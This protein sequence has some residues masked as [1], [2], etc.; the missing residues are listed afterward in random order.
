MA[1]QKDITLRILIE[2]V[3]KTGKALE[4]V[5]DR[6]NKVV[7][8]LKAASDSTAPLGDA[9]SSVGRTAEAMADG[10]AKAGEAIANSVE[11]TT[12]ATEDTKKA[13]ADGAADVENYGQKIV[14]WFDKS[15]LS[16][17]RLGDFLSSLSI[18]LGSTMFTLAALASST[19]AVFA[20]LRA[21]V[22][23]TGEEFDKTEKVI[24]DFSMRSKFSIKE[25]SD[26]V[27]TLVTGGMTL[28]QVWTDVGHALNLALITAT[29]PAQAAQSAIQTLQ[30]FQLPMDQ[31]ASVV[32]KLA[33]AAANSNQS[34]GQIATSLQKV[35][36]LADQAGISMDQLVAMSNLLGKSG[37]SL[38]EL[39]M[40]FSRMTKQTGDQ[41]QM[42]KYLG[43]ESLRSTNGVLKFYDTMKALSELKLD[44]EVLS[45]LF[46]LSSRSGAAALRIILDNVDA[47]KDLED[48]YSKTGGAAQ[49]MASIHS[50]TLSAALSQLKNSIVILADTVG[51]N[52]LDSVTR[53]VDKVTEWVQ[54]LQKW[55]DSMD[56][57]QKEIASFSVSI[58]T[59]AGA[60]GGALVVIGLLIQAFAFLSTQAGI[61][62]K[63]LQGF[64]VF[65]GLTLLFESLGAA[66]LTARNALLAIITTS[67]A[68][69]AAFSAFAAVL[70]SLVIMKLIE[71]WDVVQK[72][73][74]A[75]DR[76]DKQT[77]RAQTAQD[78]L[79]A[80][81]GE[82]NKQTGLNVK[83]VEELN[84]VIKKGLVIKDE[85]TKLWRQT[86]QAEKD[87]GVTAHNTAASYA[88]LNQMLREN[89]IEQ[90][91]IAALPESTGK[92]ARQMEA[93]I[94]ALKTKNTEYDALK[95][96]AEAG[97]EEA[98]RLAL[99]WEQSIRRKYGLQM[100]E[101]DIAQKRGIRAAKTEED[102]LYNEET[103][104]LYKYF[105]DRR[106]VDVEDYLRVKKEITLA[107]IDAEIAETEKK[108]KEAEMTKP[109]EAPVIR[110]QLITLTQKRT[111]AETK[112]DIETATIREADFERE[113]KI[114]IEESR[115]RQKAYGDDLA[116]MR[117]NFDEKLRQ[118]DLYDQTALANSKLTAEERLALEQSQL[119]ARDR[120]VRDYFL[121]EEQAYLQH[122][123]ELL[124]ITESSINARD[125]FAGAE[126]LLQLKQEQ[127]DIE[128]EMLINHL[129]QVTGLEEEDE[130]IRDAR[131]KRAMA[132]A[133]KFTED[134][135]T[136]LQNQFSFAG[137]IT[138][139]LGDAFGQLYAATG[140][141]QKAF[142]YAQKALNIATAIANVATGVT[143]ALKLGPW[144]MAL[145]AAIAAAGGVQ[146]GII[147]AQRPPEMAEG[148]PV[149]GGSGRRDDVPIMAM[150][151]EYVLRKS[152]VEK[153]G[154]SFIEALNRGIVE[155]PREWAAMFTAKIPNITTPAFAF[156]SGG[157]VVAGGS[158]FA[159]ARE[160]PQELSIVN[161]IDPQLM[162][163]Y[164][165][166]SAGQKMLVNVLAANAYQVRKVIFQ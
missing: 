145:A 41:L 4:G 62:L 97:D 80:T 50:D 38:D 151:G 67:G 147:A 59:W 150:G 31:F 154:V 165:A 9:L 161:V 15:G 153:Y 77:K 119:A 30:A 33:Y 148:G 48:R 3:D 155:I 44:P 159:A 89:A 43:L 1:D 162:E 58:V 14:N 106:I 74:D 51:K 135:L 163:R 149:K 87:A 5:R 49:R 23:M 7:D 83:T 52:Y 140:K 39:T 156:A 25:V 37:H 6:A 54:S 107:E 10:I 56:P 115:I 141:K 136:T 17:M 134:Y 103:L 88:L 11:K 112:T 75:L 92:L 96:R 20:G 122:Q 45:K 47:L 138:S 123:Q 157:A 53:A 82:F 137:R 152:A 100:A 40:V 164:M 68:A 34:L 144:G 110:Q 126:A 104:A 86:T 18:I 102:R 24:T 124:S 85:N 61:A 21:R 114:L 146:I 57:V 46:G 65:Q 99:E 127:Y 121:K 158:P 73:L 55:L 111:T 27:D 78:A 16:V 72:Y 19:E 12:K 128:T 166:S 93:D 120:M 60:I 70:A 142:F 26:A 131:N 143:E 2:A 64:F 117:K 71:L 76:L 95:R 130:E 133:T 101:M 66:I 108:L 79:N 91:K 160:R 109:M 81:L 129:K 132:K 98:A 139:T 118:Q 13:T 125:P 28:S 116:T 22:E 105:Y 8:A 42:I 84:D 94:N 63:V 69:A 113:Q 32:D 36:P 90:S 35:A 29:T